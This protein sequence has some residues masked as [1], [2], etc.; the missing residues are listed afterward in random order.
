MSPKWCND[1]GLY[2]K[3]IEEFLPL[4]QNVL[5]IYLSSL[6]YLYKTMTYLGILCFVSTPWKQHISCHTE[7]GSTVAP[8]VSALQTSRLILLENS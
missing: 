2:Q 7:G 4:F 5:F 3:A 1:A 8:S 6:I